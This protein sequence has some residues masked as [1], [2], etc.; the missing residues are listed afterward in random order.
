MIRRSTVVLL[1]FCLIV[2]GIVGFNAFLQNQPPVTYTL[3][4][5][6]SIQGW[7]SALVGEFN[8]RGA[9]LSS[10]VRAQWRV[11]ATVSDINVWQ[12]RSNWTN[13][14]HPDAWLATTSWVV[15][16]APS[17]LSF[18]RVE[19]SL[20]LSP[21]VWGGFESRV[22]LLTQEGAEPF[23][24][25]SA[26]RVAAQERWAAL[27]APSEWGFV[28]IGIPWPR[29]SAAGVNVMASMLAAYTGSPALRSSTFADSGFRAWFAPLRQAMR[30]SERLG[31]PPPSV[32]ASRGSVVAGF[33]LAPEFEWLAQLSSY[34]PQDRWVLAYPAIQAPLDFPLSVWQ[35]AETT[36]AAHQAA[37]A[38]ANFVLS[39][40]GQAIT[41]Q[42]GLRPLNRAPGAGDARFA[43]GQPYGIVL[44]WQPGEVAQGDRSVYEQ[45]FRLMD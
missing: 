6:P 13:E 34:A 35:S 22:R 31:E 44:D 41:L 43:Q 19:P 26:Q 18:V 20:A 11:D 27:G 29:S 12:G 38:L 2:G 36:D 24:W 32:M 23:D 3:A 21:L 45:L 8:A 28:N 10:G 7:A 1:L 5:D 40:A 37:R 39:E 17:N 42:A 14:R 30:S 9:T 4:V 16:N 33:S 15:V 25:A